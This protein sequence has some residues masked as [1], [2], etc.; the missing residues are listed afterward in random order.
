VAST[1][2]LPLRI[3]RQPFSFKPQSDHGTASRRSADV[4]S[5]C[6]GSVSGHSAVQ[7]RCP[8]YP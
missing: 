6:D 2:R 7:S 3:I 5:R 8:L 4:A 1:Y